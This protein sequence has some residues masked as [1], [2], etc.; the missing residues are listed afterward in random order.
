MYGLDEKY[1]ET[2][3]AWNW[4]VL[5]LGTVQHQVKDRL[6]ITSGLDEPRDIMLD[7]SKGSVVE[8]DTEGNKTPYLIIRCIPF[9][10]KRQREIGSVPNFLFC[11][12]SVVALA[13]EKNCY[14]R[15][16]YSYSV[17]GLFITDNQIPPAVI[18]VGHYHFAS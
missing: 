10:E 13:K 7:I 4:Q 11:K 6:L 16:K 5:G 15:G 17:S 2:K 8:M 12:R 3:K 14:C 1:D 18:S 9:T